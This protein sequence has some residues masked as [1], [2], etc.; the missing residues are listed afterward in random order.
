MTPRPPVVEPV[1]TTPP[2]EPVE[3]RVSTSSTSEAPRVRPGVAFSVLPLPDGVT[4]LVLDVPV[5]PLTALRAVVPDGVERRAVALL[6]PGFTGSREDHR[7]L[8]PLLAARGVEAWT[9]SQ[10]GQA[11]SAAPRGVGAYRL[12]DFTDDALDVAAVVAADAGIAPGALHLLGHSFGG[13][14]AAATAVREPGA[15]ASL[16]MLCSGPHGW[17]G[18]K[19]AERARLLAAAGQ[20]DLWSLDNPDLA[21]RL[22]A[23]P[24]ALDA[25]D[26]DARFHRDRSI[27]T[28]VDN[29][30]GA[31]DVLAD[32]HDVTPDLAATALPVLVAHGVDDAAWPQP[33]QRAMA[34]RLGARHAVIDDA[35]HLPNVENPAATADLLAGF[36]TS[37]AAH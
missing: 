12:D 1:E 2:V 9:Y 13:T 26:D 25:L 33:W 19:D 36:W 23:D 17:P 7:L 16:T 8:L 27:A 18:R 37:A 30:L 29:L 32:I 28:S 21:R 11:D 6:V 31:I 14:V 22:A 15:F 24:A 10:R 5:G 3:T 20:V 34:E 35:G 4:P